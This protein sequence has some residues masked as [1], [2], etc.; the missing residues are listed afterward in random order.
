MIQPNLRV[1]L[2]KKSNNLDVK[3]KLRTG[4]YSLKGMTKNL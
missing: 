2:N 1:S 4:K 3:W